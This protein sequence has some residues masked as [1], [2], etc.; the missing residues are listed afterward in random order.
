[1]SAAQV[2]T[3]G[4]L[5]R[6][7]VAVG[8]LVASAACSASSHQAG[9]TAGLPRSSPTSSP[10]DSA[11]KLPRGV[12]QSVRVDP[13]SA[14][15][16][17]AFGFGSIWLVT[18]RQTEL[19]RIDP[20]SG[21]VQKTIRV[22]DEACCVPV[23]AGGRVWDG[24]DAIDPK[25]NQVVAEVKEPGP[26]SVLL[27]VNGTPWAGSGQTLQRIDPSSARIVQR[28][29]VNA[30]P[31]KVSVPDL[32]VAYGD[33]M[34]W[35]IDVADSDETFG[36]VV[37]EVDPKSGREVHRYSVP[38][39]GGYA[40]VQFL[41]HAVWLKGDSNGRLVKLD[42]R[43]GR[44]TVYM[45]PNFVSFDG[46]FPHNIAIGLGA[47]W[48]RVQSG[49]VVRFDPRSGRVTGRYPAD[50][51]AGGGFIAVADGSLWEPNFDSG[52]LWRVRL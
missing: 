44:S 11:A 34:F 14:P 42:T 26:A 48:V 51:A 49:L 45:L 24:V 8:A 13:A 16:G 31:R 21:V 19:F 15:L 29:K 2:M 4:R 43:T 40:D 41:D 17:A 9:G 6:V 1:M 20:V 12:L 50:P 39:P 33:G 5:V 38:D 28:I 52:T 32:E 23:I 18:H 27:S 36:G 3:V 10:P 47:I 37:V 22:S 30:N 7:A 46:L 35:A 25:T